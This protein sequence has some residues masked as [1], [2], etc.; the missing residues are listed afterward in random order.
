MKIDNAI[1]GVDDKKCYQQLWP[2]VARIWNILG[3]T[4]RLYWVTN[5]KENFPYPSPYGTIT[6]LPILPMYSR[7]FLWGEEQCS[8]Y[9]SMLARMYGCATA[10]GVNILADI[11][12]FPLSRRFFIDN[13]EIYKPDQMIILGASFEYFIMGHR[14]SSN[15]H[16]GKNTSF[17][18]MIYL[19]RAPAWDVGY[20]Q[21]AQRCTLEAQERDPQPWMDELHTFEYNDEYYL[22]Q[23]LMTW[24]N[25]E[26]N[27]AVILPRWRGKRVVL[28]NLSENF[29]A[30]ITGGIDAHFRATEITD[31][32]LVH[33]FADKVYERLTNYR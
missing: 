11:D 7:G 6:K 19:Q 23:K 16:V 17:A 13:L 33:R 29:D 27:S 25:D 28:A 1:I 21:D 9:E 10:S 3:V 14:F 5:S 15:Y 32:D 20:V 22:F 2:D 26:N 24:V 18:K 30:L 12:M 31:F 4:P 8:G